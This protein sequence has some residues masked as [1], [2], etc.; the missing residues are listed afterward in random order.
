MEI[1]KDYSTREAIHRENEKQLEARL[2]IKNLKIREE[3]ARRLQRRRILVRLNVTLS[4]IGSLA[5]AYV[6]YKDTTEYKNNE[7]YVQ[8]I[9]KIM[10]TSTE[11]EQVAIILTAI[12]E[13]QSNDFEKGFRKDEINELKSLYFEIERAN[14]KEKYDLITKA[15]I[16]SSKAA[17]VRINN[18]S[19]TPKLG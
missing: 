13:L 8:E 10:E 9:S 19:E 11:N 18:N 5:I 3:K 4:L 2:R 14:G 6:A 15:L 16:L 12:E 7:K 17:H 1:I